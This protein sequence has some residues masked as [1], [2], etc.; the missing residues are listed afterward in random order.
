VRVK[1][2]YTVEVENVLKEVS[3]IF[4]LQQEE[5][6]LMVLAYNGLLEDLSR[7]DVDIF[8]TLRK[9]EDLRASLLNLDMRAAEMSEVLRGYGEYQT[10][11]RRSPEDTEEEVE[12]G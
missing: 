4:G 1:L 7:K 5:V 10:A 2:S 8:K 11:L 6:Q 3:K 12:N 9:L